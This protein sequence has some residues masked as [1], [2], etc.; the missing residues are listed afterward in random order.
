MHR[1]T[2][3]FVML[4]SVELYCI[5]PEIVFKFWRF[6]RPFIFAASARTGLT[7]PE[8]TEYGVLVGDHLLWI[9]W[10]GEIKAAA[11]T[12]LSDNVCTFTA[13]GGKDMSQ[14][15]RFFPRFEKYASDEGCVLRIAGRK[16]WQRALRRAGFSAETTIF[17]RPV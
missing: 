16:G 8:E 1:P 4:S 12:H 5:D 7:D 2:E 6:A 11:T 9:V 15:I 17:E 14:W 10:D 3:R 13:C